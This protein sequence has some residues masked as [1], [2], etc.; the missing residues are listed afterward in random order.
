MADA[1]KT[2][3]AVKNILIVED[4]EDQRLR[5]KY[6]LESEGYK[7]DESSNADQAIELIGRKKYD[8]VITDL[9]MP[10]SRSGMDVLSAAR[11]VSEETEVIIVTAYGTVDNAVQAMIN[12]AFDY[13]QKP[14]NMPELRLKVERA[15]R[16]AALLRDSG[17]REVL[18]NN[19][20]MVLREADQLRAR[21]K[22]IAVL[23]R[24]LLD[25]HETN[26]G[27]V[28]EVAGKILEKARV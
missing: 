14:V 21:T 17:S 16:Q 27:K 13:L 7:T 24:S 25:D 26:L 23:A 22:E 6:V 10:G 28:L 19:F 3:K 12:G 2:G 15:L 5:L 9:K 1:G 8:L 4:E 20:N 11:T 18:R